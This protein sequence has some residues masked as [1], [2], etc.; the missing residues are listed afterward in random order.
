MTETYQPAVVYCRV[1]DAKQKIEGHGLESQ[2]VRCVEYA[3]R[4]G[5]DVVGVFKDDASGGAAERP[6]FAK[7]LAYLAANR[8]D[9]H[10]VIVD[11]INRVSRSLDVHLLFRKKIGELGARFESPTMKFGDGADDRM[12][13]M[14]LVN[15]AEYQRNKNAEQTRNR[16]WG[17]IMN[18]YWVFQAPRGYKYEKVGAHGKLLVRDEPVAS[19][20]QAALEGYANGTFQTLT[21]VKRYLESQPDFPKDTK[22]GEVRIQRIREWLTQVLY[23]GFI[24]RPDWGIELREA[25]H[26]GLVSMRT[27]RKI[28]DRL[29]G[30]VSDLAK[31]PVRKDLKEEMPLR[32]F[33]QCGDC[34]RPLTGA[35][36]KGRS[37]YYF[38]YEC[39]N[40]ECDSYR[41][42]IRK[43]D[44][45]KDFE[46]LLA[47]AKP[48][49]KLYDFVYIM[50][51]DLWSQHGERLLEEKR[52]LKA[53]LRELDAQ[54]ET[55]VDR[56]LETS[57]ATL[58][59]RYE[60]RLRDLEQ[61]KAALVEQSALPAKA[62]DTF[63][64]TFRTAMGFLANPLKLWNS[65][66]FEDKRAVLKLT[67]ADQLAYKRN[68]GFR[69]A[70]FSLPFKLLGGF[71]TLENKM[72]HPRG[73]EPLAS[74][75]GG[76]LPTLF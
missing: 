36:S 14:M 52:S 25:Q 49:R 74:A 51:K 68:E 27:F 1:S 21:E 45:E 37:K 43:A 56:T 58:I 5:Y 12:V 34:D 4:C 26:D 70:N 11:D 40:K 66:R 23:A 6:E 18:G 61:E 53:Q 9:Q 19:I 33:V 39:H 3:K 22:Q 48:T 54:I 64:R 65:S 15:V 72:V 7:M 8:K 2:E 57:S 67:F 41:K 29:A 62:L 32:G 46:M 42:S 35:R 20:M 30:R 76:Q 59:A 50:L 31:A 38:Y 55:I 60:E 69:T 73:F 75:F 17:R 28:Q 10:V 44:I 63:E 13:E 71:S 47:T 24:E 16:M